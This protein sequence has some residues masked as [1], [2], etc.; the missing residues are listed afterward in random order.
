MQPFVVKLSSLAPG[1]NLLEWHAGAQFFES[2]GNED[3]LAADLQV[4]AHVTFRGITAEVSCT[5]TGTVT[6]PCDRCLEDLIIPVDTSFGE[7]Y[8]PLGDEL[9]FSQDV[10][11]Y[12]CTS[13]PLQRL[14]PEG[15]CNQ[16]TTK[17]LSK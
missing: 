13:I 4:T 1:S 12:V 2:F 5:V 7:T 8:A 9:D 6:V 11:D 10:Y 16:E 17:F 15:D 3:I 14:H